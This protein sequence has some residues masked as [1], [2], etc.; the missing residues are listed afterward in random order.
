L[1]ISTQVLNGQLTLVTDT[2]PE[3]CARY[4]IYIPMLNQ[5]IR[6]EH[7]SLQEQ[8]LHR[9][10]QRIFKPLIL[11]HLIIQSQPVAFKKI[12]I[13]HIQRIDKHLFV[14]IPYAP[15]TV[16][17]RVIVFVA[18]FQYTGL[19]DR[20]YKGCLESADT[21]LV[22]TRYLLGKVVSIVLDRLSGMRVHTFEII[23]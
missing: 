6:I 2:K 3:T 15:S 17:C 1:I 9:K 10:T 11:I 21:A 5:C 23:I 18:N 16:Y 4:D 20:L 19:I 8:W 22:V 7:V 12:G 14:G 13:I